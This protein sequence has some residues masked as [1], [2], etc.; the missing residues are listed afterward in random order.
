MR[1]WEGTELAFTSRVAESGVRVSPSGSV[2]SS[3]SWRRLQEASKAA[4]AKGAC[5]TDSSLISPDIS[6][7]QLGI[8]GLDKEFK[9]I[10]R[11][12]F[13][14]RVL[15]PPLVKEMGLKHVRG[16]LLYGPPGTGKTL[17][18]RQIGGALRARPPKV[19]SGPEVLNKY[20]GQ[21]EENVRNLFKEA[22]EEEQK[23]GDKSG[24]HIIIF[25]EID[26]ICK[27][28][29][30]GAGGGGGAGVGV[31]DSIVNQLLS[32]I[33]GVNALNNI[34]L[35]GMTNRLDL[36]DE[37]LL[38]PGRFEVLIEIGLPNAQGRKQILTIHTAAMHAA[39]RLAADVDLGLL[40][41]ATLNFSG[42]ELE[43]L[44]RAAASFAFQRSI[45][46]KDLAKTRNT[47]NMQICMQDF[48]AA[49]KEVKPAFGAESDAMARCLQNGIIFFSSACKRIQEIG[50]T[51]GAQVR[52]SPVALVASL[53]LQQQTPGCGASAAAAAAA[54][55]LSFPFSKFVSAENYVGFSEASKILMLNKTFQD[56]YKSNLSLVLLDD[57][58]RLVDFTPIGPRYL[59]QHITQNNSYY[60]KSIL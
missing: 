38:R 21:S 29:G 7:E 36:I 8:G 33:D 55:F 5:S 60:P 45:D 34:L 26:A 16:L 6:F 32:K 12:A 14:S 59:L 51:L 3:S 37:A 10:F 19:V 1:L 53:L 35:I 17:I 48:E 23:K 4:S 20:V 43:G 57:L 9:E 25:D 22:E 11:R 2:F 41:D 54:R 40:A 46:E 52:D 31:N 13:A 24:L 56:A 44:V 42:A 50:I 30:G 15:P 47:E 39:N 49:L 58:E 27:Q 18:A 28:R